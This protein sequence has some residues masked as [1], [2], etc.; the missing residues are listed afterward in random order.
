MKFEDYVVPGAD[1]GPENPYPV[2]RKLEFNHEYDCDA[3]NVPLDERDTLGFATGFR[4]LPYRMQDR[5]SSSREPKKFFSAVLENKY[6]KVRILPQ[7]GGLVSS[8]LWKPLKRDLIY[9]NPVFQPRNLALRDAWV[10]GGIEF[11]TAQLGHHY[12]TCSPVNMALVKDGDEEFIRIFA[13]ERVKAFPYM[14]DMH[15]PKDSPFFYIHVRIINPHDYMIPMY[16]WTNIGCEEY[17]DGRVIAPCDETYETHGSSLRYVNCPVIEGVDKSYVSHQRNAYDLFF[18]IPPERRKWEVLV[19]KH[20]KGILHVAT[21]MLKSTKVFAWGNN[22]GSLHWSEYLSKD[23]HKPFQEI[24]FG[25]APTQMHSEKMPPKTVWEWTEAISYFKGDKKILHGDWVEAYTYGTEKV[26]AMLSREALEEMDKKYTKAAE[27]K[28]EKLVY[29][30]LGWGALE[31]ELREVVDFDN[32]PMPIPSYLPFDTGAMGEDQKMWMDLLYTGI[33]NERDIYDDPGQYMIQPEWEQLLEESINDRLS[34]NWFAWFHLGVMKREKVAPEGSK[35]SVCME[36]AEECFKKSLECKENQYALYSL[37]RISLDKGDEK[38]SEEYLMR[39]LKVALAGKDAKIDHASYIAPVVMAKLIKE[40]RFEEAHKIYKSLPKRTKESERVRLQWGYLA[41]EL[42]KQR[43]VKKVLE[44]H[45]DN[46]AEG[47]VSVTGLW[48]KYYS[49]KVAKR[50]G[51]EWSEEL[52][53]E[54]KN[55]VAPPHDLDFRMFVGDG[56]YVPPTER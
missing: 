35:Y 27:I 17:P 13:W 12:L 16:W 38:V 49:K 19:D 28:P 24:Q 56:V 32:P 15:L 45:F 53:E 18:H 21:D 39:A 37:Y 46:I 40:K 52:L 2:F 29:H 4:V 14:V 55:T 6:L 44:T 41:F 50:R 9:E 25:V 36:E 1:M 22:P 42:G 8:I 20:G 5:Y 10:S 54:I 33:F 47:E 34:D 51:V 48:Y 26:D 3:L 43:E 23:G 30:G 7:L 11:N 31:K